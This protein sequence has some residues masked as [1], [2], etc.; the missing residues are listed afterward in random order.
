MHGTARHKVALHGVHNQSHQI[1]PPARSPTEP[2]HTCA[3]PCLPAADLMDLV[4]AWCQGVRFAD[5]CK[6]TDVFE[7]GAALGA[8]PC[9]AVPCCVR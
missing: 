8:V 3:P 9:C 2:P 7:V 1:P 6:M 4:A 5:L